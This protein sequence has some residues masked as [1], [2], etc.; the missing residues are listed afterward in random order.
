[1]SGLE[2]LGL[3]C[4]IFQVISFGR[5]TS[6]LVKRVYR[7]SSVDDA[8]EANAKD[9]AQLASF[10]QALETPKNP[11]KQEH[12]LLEIAKNCQAVA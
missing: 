3:A 6:S 8:L 4:N 11:T 5:E 1:M 2:A 12:Q 7:D 10:V 9:L